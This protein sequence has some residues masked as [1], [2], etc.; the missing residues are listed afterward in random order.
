ML[1]SI[2]KQI[3]EQKRKMLYNSRTAAN[4]SNGTGQKTCNFLMSMTKEN[5]FMQGSECN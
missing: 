5:N 1:K 4:T 3:D 2:D